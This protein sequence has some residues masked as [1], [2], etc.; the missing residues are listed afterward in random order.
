MC[1]G[2]DPTSRRA[3]CCASRGN[4]NRS[5]VRSMRLRNPKRWSDCS[6]E[7][8]EEETQRKATTVSAVSR[9]NSGL[10]SSNQAKLY[11]TAEEQ[12]RKHKK[13]E[14]TDLQQNTV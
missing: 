13:V 2:C 4:V 3:D 5:G 9:R 14:R 6:S 1:T 11:G 12:T 7:M 10:D 8:R